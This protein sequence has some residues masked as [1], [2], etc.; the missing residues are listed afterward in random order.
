[1]HALIPLSVEESS[2]KVGKEFE[3]LEEDQN[4]RVRESKEEKHFKKVT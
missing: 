2:K 1:M 3:K 4:G